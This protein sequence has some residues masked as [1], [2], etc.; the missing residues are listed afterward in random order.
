MTR[1]DRAGH[2]G[3]VLSGAAGDQ[4]A[5]LSVLGTQYCPSPECGAEVKKE[6]VPVTAATVTTTTVWTH[7]VTSRLMPPESP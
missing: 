4:Q 5:G 1:G 2:R 7:T 6:A 3:A